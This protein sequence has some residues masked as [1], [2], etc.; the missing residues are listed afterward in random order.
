MCGKAPS[1][2][3]LATWLCCW[4][5]PKGEE[6]TT[7]S[8]GFQGGLQSVPR[9]MLISWTSRQQPV[10]YTEKPLPRKDKEEMGVSA[11]SLWAKPWVR[12]C[13]ECLYTI[14]SIFLVFYSQWDLEMWASLALRAKCQGV[15]HSL[16]GNL[17]TSDPRYSVQTFH[18]S[19]RSWEL[20]FPPD[21]MLLCQSGVESVAQPFLLI[22]MWVFSQ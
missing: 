9:R 12:S 15:G 13:G 20:G 21:F 14:N 18:S 10:K 3:I 2:E 1:W 17:K 16:G 11:C 19:R 7:C 5:E 4:N 6:V 22:S 8:F